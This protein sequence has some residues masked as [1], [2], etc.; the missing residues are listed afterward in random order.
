MNIG[1]FQADGVLYART[2]KASTLSQFQEEMGDPDQVALDLF[3]GNRSKHSL[4]MVALD[5]LIALD[6]NEDSICFALE[7]VFV[8]IYRM[9]LRKGQS[10]SAEEKA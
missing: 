7:D 5:A 10:Q 3:L 9:G 4:G 1:F 6:T 2:T 8:E